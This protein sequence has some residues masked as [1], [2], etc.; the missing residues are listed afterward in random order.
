MRRPAARG[1]AGQRRYDRRGRPGPGR[2]G[3]DREIDASRMIVAP[4]AGGDPLAYVEH[5]AAQHV[6]GGPRRDTSASRSASG[7]P[8]A[9]ATSLQGT[10]WP[11]WRPSA[12]ASPPCT[13]GATTSAARP[14]PTLGVRALAGRACGPGSPTGARPGSQRSA[15]DLHD[16]RRLHTEWDGRAAGGLLSLGLACRGLGAAT[17]TCGA[18]GR[19]TARS[20]RQP[21][22][23]ASRSPSMPAGRGRPPGR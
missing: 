18:R 9:P 2:A 6:G 15:M 4:G 7:P 19:S 23:W 11:A 20:S 5:A 14:M 10:R 17:P 13:T 16:L 22:T 12:P 3:R 1:R 21:A 8:S